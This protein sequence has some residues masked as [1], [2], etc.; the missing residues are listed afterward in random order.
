MKKIGGVIACILTLF[1]LTGCSTTWEETWAGLADSDLDLLID[2]M[3]EVAVDMLLESEGKEGTI[4]Q[5]NVAPSILEETASANTNVG[6][7]FYYNQRGDGVFQFGVFVDEIEVLQSGW[8]IEGMLL[9]KSVLE[10]TVKDEIFQEEEG[11]SFEYTF[12]T[13]D[14]SGSVLQES[15]LCTVVGASEL[16]EEWMEFTYVQADGAEQHRYVDSEGQ[17]RGLEGEYMRNARETAYFLV[18]LAVTMKDDFYTGITKNYDDLDE[19]YQ[20]RQETQSVN[21]EFRVFVVEITV[22]EG[23]VTEVRGV[24]Y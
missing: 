19:F 16:K 2:G 14:H 15:V 17:V 24:Q 5:G 1:C 20:Y 10:E 21:E 11:Y 23:V 8:A 18:P 12:Y 3:L 7:A 4:T 9:D 22:E 13:Y 6:E